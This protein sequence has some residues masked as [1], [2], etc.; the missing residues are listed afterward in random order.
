MQVGAAN[1]Q[2]K[3]KIRLQSR[4]DMAQGVNVMAQVLK[5]PDGILLFMSAP[6]RHA[7]PKPPARSAL[8]VAFDVDLVDDHESSGLDQRCEMRTRLLERVDMMQ[9]N[10]RHCRVE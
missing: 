2:P 7:L 4:I 8:V 10:H 1:G 6:Q 9:R 5:Q 3:L